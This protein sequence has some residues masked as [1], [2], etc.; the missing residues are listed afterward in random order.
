[1]TLAPSA[2]IIFRIAKHATI[3]QYALYVILI[4][5]LLQ[6]V[7]KQNVMVAIISVQHAR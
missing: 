6:E 7:A 1:M 5:I 4:F 2:K 3:R